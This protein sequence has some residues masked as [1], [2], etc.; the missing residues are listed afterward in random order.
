MALM[1]ATY[2]ALYLM[3][4]ASAGVAGAKPPRG[5]YAVDDD[6]KEGAGGSF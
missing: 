3:R 5:M 6:K 1:I 4:P 2:I